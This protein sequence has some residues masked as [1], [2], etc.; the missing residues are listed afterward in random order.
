MASMIMS[1]RT[2]TGQVSTRET[3]SSANVSGLWIC[4]TLGHP[5]DRP[6]CCINQDILV[7]IVATT[8]PAD[9]ALPRVTM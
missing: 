3:S 1:T 6:R 4:L 8:T 2:K 5:W 7:V 9:Q